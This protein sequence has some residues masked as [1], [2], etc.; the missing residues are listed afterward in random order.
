MK[1]GC[2]T[3]SE[4]RFPAPSSLKEGCR[5]PMLGV[6][7]PYCPVAHGSRRA[8]CPH[9]AGPKRLIAEGTSGQY[10]QDL[11]YRVFVCVCERTAGVG[12]RQRRIAYSMITAAISGLLSTSSGWERNELCGLCHDRLASGW[13][14]HRGGWGRRRGRGAPGGAA[15]ELYSLSWHVGVWEAR[16]RRRRRRKPCPA[17]VVNFSR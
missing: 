12:P 8:Y 17:V 2:R 11:L 13:F 4:H 7:L 16:R 15:C 14:E 5:K 10:V 9:R 3:H 1:R 6:W